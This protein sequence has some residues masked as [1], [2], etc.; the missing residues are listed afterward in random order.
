MFPVS[1]DCLFLIDPSVFSNIN[2]NF[3][4]TPIIYY[5]R[6]HLSGICSGTYHVDRSEKEENMESH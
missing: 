2:S 3:D 6:S 1:L 4:I 5:I